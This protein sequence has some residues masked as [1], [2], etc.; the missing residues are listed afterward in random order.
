ML[1]FKSVGLNIIEDLQGMDSEVSLDSK[2]TTLGNYI[3]DYAPLFIFS[4]NYYPFIALLSERL[5]IPYVSVTSDCPV[6][7][8]YNTSIKSEYNRIF[9]FD[10]YQ[11]NEI[12]KLNPEHVFYLP[13]GACTERFDKVL[14]NTSTLKYDV[15]FVGS[16]YQNNLLS[17]PTYSESQKEAIENICKKQIEESSFG[18][19]VTDCLVSQ[20][21]VEAIKTNSANF[22]SSALCTH[23]IDRNVAIDNYIGPYIT[24]R[25]RTEML[26]KL[27]ESLPDGSIYLFTGS[28]VSNLSNKI[29]THPPIS[30]GIEMP[31]VFRQTKINLNF[32]LR[33]IRSGIPQ[34]IWDVLACRGFLITNAQPELELYFKQGVH[35]ETYSTID[36][37]IDKT[38]YYLSHDSLRENIAQ[39]GYE[40]VSSHHKTIDRVIQIVKTISNIK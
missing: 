37:L 21:L 30:S 25:E 6:L 14:S 15:S 35:L 22:Y 2:I 8:L 5:K 1:A 11:F 32:T 20:E 40:L 19:N 26:N 9:L 13:L 28:D 33:S 36:E 3:C 23:T 31:N 4:M 18:L 12:Q 39:K 29:I 16:L 34:R 38:S 24:F 7:E 27:S 10:K 17:N